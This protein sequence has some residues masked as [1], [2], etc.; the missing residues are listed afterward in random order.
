MK[1]LRMLASA[2]R[3]GSAA[4]GTRWCPCVHQTGREHHGQGHRSPSRAI[5][6]SRWFHVKKRRHSV[7]F[8]NIPERPALSLNRGFSAP[9]TLSAN[10]FVG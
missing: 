6:A 10:G 3:P 2:S 7:R 8:K 5:I 4:T 9:I 1:M